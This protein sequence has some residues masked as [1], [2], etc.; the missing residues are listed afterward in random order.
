MMRMNKNEE[1]FESEEKKGIEE[2]LSRIRQYEKQKEKYN[3]KYK[4]QLTRK[5]AEL[6]E[7]ISTSLAEFDVEIDEPSIAV[8]AEAKKYREKGCVVYPAVLRDE[9]GKAKLCFVYRNESGVVDRVDAGSAPLVD[10]LAVSQIIS[11]FQ[12][13]VE[14][15]IIDAM[16]KRSEEEYE[17]IAEFMKRAA[18]A[19]KHY[20][21][22]LDT[23][24]SIRED[25]PE[26]S[27]TS[28][29]ESGRR[30]RS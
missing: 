24:K 26:E 18:E 1:G 22:L 4:P 9:D 19:Y 5:F 21:G 20:T 12:S 11:E 28:G 27:R 15:A 17:K 7:E 29:S 14:E 3:V 10:V 25:R 23:I 30:G 16:L 8:P 6:L 13:L 2:K